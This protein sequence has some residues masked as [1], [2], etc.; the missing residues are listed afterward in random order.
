MGTAAGLGEEWGLGGGPGE[1][2]VIKVGPGRAWEGLRRDRGQG[3]PGEK[4]QGPT[5]G[6][7]EQR[8]SGPQTHSEASHQCTLQEADQD[9]A[10]VVFV[11]RHAGV[12][13]IE[14]K[15][16]QEELH[17]GPQQPCPLPAEPRLHI[18]LRG[19]RA[20]AQPTC[21][22]DSRSSRLGAS[23]CWEQN[24]QPLQSPRPSSHPILQRNRSPVAKGV[25]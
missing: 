20:G 14:G 3:R 23:R 16:H 12:A 19:Q 18:E 4:K 7:P 22:A 15:G 9:I 6:S 5:A 17:R 2:T 8:G 10:P 21:T 13:H 1:G 11:V 25:K 24:R